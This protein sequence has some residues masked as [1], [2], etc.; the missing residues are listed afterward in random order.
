MPA[1]T[2][3]IK[4]SSAHVPEARHHVKKFARATVARR[5]LDML[6]EAEIHRLVRIA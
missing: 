4:A 2:S 1:S 3:R 5:V 6:F